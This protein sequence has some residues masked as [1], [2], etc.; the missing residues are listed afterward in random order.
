MKWTALA[1]LS[2]LLFSNEVC[3]A[4]EAEG[5]ADR[6]PAPAAAKAPDL[7]KIRKVYFETEWAE[8]DNARP[9]EANWIEKRTC[10]KIVDTLEAAD[11]ILTWSNQ[12]LTGV[13]VELESKDRETLWA[14]RGLRPPLGALKQALGCPK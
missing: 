4:R 7:H 10:L 13:Y 9:R 14:K 11:A 8:D 5:A 1:I 3:P 2:L 6:K 12:G